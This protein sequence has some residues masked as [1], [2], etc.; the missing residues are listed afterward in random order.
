M[1]SLDGRTCVVTGA[2]SGLGREY[3]LLV[4]SEGAS[5][6]VN[7]R[8][9]ATDGLGSDPSPAQETVARIRAAGGVAVANAD[10]VADW[11]TGARLVAQALDE[12]G[13]LDVIVNN[14]GVTC[15]RELV[16]MTRDEYERIIGIHLTGH[17][18]L[19]RAAAGHWRTQYEQGMPV[20]GSI[21]NT[22]SGIM[23]GAAG[24][25]DYSAAKA[26][27][28]AATLSLAMELQ[29]YGVR[30][31]CIAPIARSRLARPETA[32]LLAPPVDPT[33]FDSNDPANVAP[34]VAVLAAES[35]TITG[36]VFHVTGNEV[37]LFRGWTL[38]RD[39]VVYADGR[40][41]IEGLVQQLP[42]LVGEA[43]LPSMRTVMADTLSHKF[44]KG[45]P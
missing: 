25:S 33:A 44:G 20:A 4:A 3:A 9:T 45:T 2:G 43:P 37:G 29:R 40:W 16:D 8:G 32:P 24:M 36:A 13:R 22:A 41:T 27:I 11:D 28:A 10:S 35:C 12:F 14:A 38:D 15:N 17:F 7:D 26:G 23:L 5:V 30:V 6:V 42:G 39:E 34:L 21:I 31:N 18:A 1:G 19:M